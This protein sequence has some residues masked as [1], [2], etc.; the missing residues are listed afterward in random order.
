VSAFLYDTAAN[1]TLGIGPHTDGS[2]YLV[3][4]FIYNLTLLLMLYIHTYIIKVIVPSY[5]IQ[6]Y[7][8]P[9]YYYSIV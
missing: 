4:L 7:H 3:L 2:T 5:G 9:V 6:Y 1:I 8:L